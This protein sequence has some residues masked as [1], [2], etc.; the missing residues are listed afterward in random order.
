MTVSLPILNT[1]RLKIRSFRYDDLVAFTAYRADPVIA[2]YQS[3]ESYVFED[4][5][6]LFEGMDY[7]LFGH[8]GMWFQ[9]A[10][11]DKSDMLIGDV[12]LHF[13][14]EQQ[15]EVG[16]TIANKY[17]QQGIATEAMSAVIEYL[18]MELNKYRIT[19]TT[20]AENLASMALL[21]KLGFRKEGHYLKNVFFKGQWGDECAYAM[22]KQDY[23]IK[24]E[25]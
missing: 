25:V 24:N 17:Q 5:K 3:W 14:D 15:M 12:A 9:L 10:I 6:G 18:F 7:S 1:E 21:E 4:A 8:A 20:D 23:V 16:F 2:Q 11:V 22:L 19:A 13:I